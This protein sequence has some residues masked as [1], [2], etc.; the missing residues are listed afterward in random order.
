MAELLAAKGYDVVAVA[1]RERRLE[2]LREQL[3]RRWR[4]RVHPLPCDL[5]DPE[6]S[7]H[8]RDEL[9]HRGLTVDV[10][11][12]NAGYA[13]LGPY[14]QHEWREHLRFVRVLGLNVAELCHMFLPHMVEQRWGRVIN[15]A[16]LAGIMSGSPGAVLYGA[17][18]SFVHK[19]TEGLAAE[20]E[21]YGIHCT[22]ALVGPTDTE[23]AVGSGFASWMD[24]NLILQL[25]MMRPEAVA[26]T[27]YNACM[28]GRR[29]VV[30]GWHQ[31]VW[32]CVLVHAPP[33]IRYGLSK[34][35]AA[36]PGDAPLSS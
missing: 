19:F 7:A 35:G 10:L 28:R 26:R 25:V 5:A 12:N 18:K 34:S 20:Y 30:P 23:F 22:V 21:P 32:R 29:V 3:E 11:V 6:A 1:R 33:R 16:S 13:L 27:T 4:V 17:T 8:L 24:S 15:V 2:E 14:L 31:Q 9:D 36:V